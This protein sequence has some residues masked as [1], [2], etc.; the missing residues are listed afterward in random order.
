MYVQDLYRY[1]TVDQAESRELKLKIAFDSIFEVSVGKG[2]SRHA[3]LAV[4]DSGCGYVCG[5][6]RHAEIERQAQ[7]HGVAVGVLGPGEAA[8]LPGV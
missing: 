8:F 7:A 5:D 4:D 1:W 3:W 2:N 6:D